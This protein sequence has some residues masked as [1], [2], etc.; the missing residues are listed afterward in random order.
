[1]RLNPYYESARLFALRCQY[2]PELVFI[3]ILKIRTL[4]DKPYIQRQ[5]WSE[6]CHLFWLELQINGGK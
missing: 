1:M 6:L 2:Y 4:L 3:S 5:K